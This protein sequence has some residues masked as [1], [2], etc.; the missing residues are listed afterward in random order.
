[1]GWWLRAKPMLSLSFL[2]FSCLVMLV[3]CWRHSDCCALHLALLAQTGPADHW[4]VK[5]VWKA[6]FVLIKIKSHI[7]YSYQIRKATPCWDCDRPFL[8]GRQGNPLH[9]CFPT[10][11]VPQP[12]TW[13]NLSTYYQALN[14]LNQV[15][16]SVATTQMCGVGGTRGPE[17]RTTALHPSY[18][19]LFANLLV[20]T[21]WYNATDLWPQRLRFTQ[22][23]TS[24]KEP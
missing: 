13:F 19:N 7:L 8:R 2:S 14:E 22:S 3:K 24:T 5:Q 23:K 21:V 9:Q 20:K 16:L 10:P 1:M 18:L 15:T 4:A 11:P 17:L 12:H 6:R